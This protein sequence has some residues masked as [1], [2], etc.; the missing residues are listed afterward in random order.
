MNRSHTV[1]PTAP[2]GWG[3]PASMVA[4]PVATGPEG[5]AGTTTG[6][7]A[8]SFWGNTPDR[9]VGAMVGVVA[10]VVGGVVAVVGG[11]VV[12]GIVVGG[13]AVVDAGPVTVICAPLSSKRLTVTLDEPRPRDAWSRL[14]LVVDTADQYVASNSTA[15]L[16]VIRAYGGA[17][18]RRRHGRVGTGRC[19]EETR[20]TR[21]GLPDTREV[22][23]GL[24]RG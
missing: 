4:D 22:R 10:G 8:R 3:S 7:A 13:V 19:R 15:T 2:H 12:G 9:A 24:Q 18:H 17:N 11:V 1:F 23:S 16:R 6:A 21:A 20:R 5:P 14:Q